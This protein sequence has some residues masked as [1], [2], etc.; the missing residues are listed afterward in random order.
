MASL[1]RLL[2]RISQAKLHGLLRS[3][4]YPRSSGIFGPLATLI[5]PGLS[6]LGTSLFSECGLF[7]RCGGLAVTSSSILPHGLPNAVESTIFVFT[8]LPDSSATCSGMQAT[9]VSVALSAPGRRFWR[10]VSCPSAHPFCKRVLFVRPGVAVVH[11]RPF[12]PH[13]V[14]NVFRSRQVPTLHRN[15]RGGLLRSASYP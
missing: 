3:A 15:L 7:V 13:S 2:R 6:F 4:S 5:L 12:T 14:P 1:R 10:Q 9:P 11:N 8:S